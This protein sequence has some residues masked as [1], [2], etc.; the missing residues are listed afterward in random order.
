MKRRI[1]E[2][3]GFLSA[4]LAFCC[5]G[6]WIVSISGIANIDLSFWKRGDQTNVSAAHGAIRLSHGT[7][8]NSRAIKRDENSWWQPLINY[9][10]PDITRL[11]LPG[12]QYRYCSSDGT[13]DAAWAVKCSL[14][15]PTIFLF[16]ISGICFWRYRRISPFAKKAT[17]PSKD[18]E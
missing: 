12:F 18:D 5:L 16:A 13:E 10:P 4:M 9:K 11:L 17:L 7:G 6:Y 14:L 15:I 3:G 2:W 8:E 1:Y